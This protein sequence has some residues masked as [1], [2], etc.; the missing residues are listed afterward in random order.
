[1]ELA[2]NKVKSL[3]IVKPKGG[4][5]DQAN[6]G[7]IMARLIELIQRGEKHFLLNCSDISGIDSNGLA[8]LISIRQKLVTIK[9]GSIALCQVS[10][11]VLKIFNITNA[12]HLFIIYRNEEEAIEAMTVNNDIE[13]CIAFLGIDGPLFQMLNRQLP[14]G[15]ELELIASDDD[16]KHQLNKRQYCAVIV[17]DT[18][19]DKL[20]QD[21]FK[22]MPHLSDMPNIILTKAPYTSELKH[23][24]QKKS[25][26]S[27]VAPYPIDE[28]ESY[29]L[30]KELSYENIK[31]LDTG[32]L[33]DAEKL[34]KN[35]TESLDEKFEIM[36]QLL[37]ALRKEGQLEAVETLQ[38]NVHKLS[39]SAG[40][41]GFVKGGE[42]C[43]QLELYLTNILQTG[44]YN[45][46]DIKEIETLFAKLAF[47][48]NIVFYKD[49]SK[50]NSALRPVTPQSIYL[51]STDTT[52]VHFF[53]DVA[54][55][56]SYKIEIEVNPDFALSRIQQ[57]NF[58]PEI[59]IVEQYFQ[60]S[61]HNGVDIISQIKA[62]F[63]SLQMKFALLID[64][65]NLEIEVKAIAAGIDYIIKKPP[66]AADV[67]SLF[68]SLS[69]DRR[70]QPYKILVVDDDIDIGNLIENTVAGYAF[71][72]KILTDE[73]KILE[74]L[75]EF[76]PH[77]LLLD[78]HLP[79]YDGWSLLKIL[80][81]NLRY[82]HL[83]VIIITATAQLQTVKNV[84]QNYDELWLKPLENSSLLKQL[85]KLAEEHYAQSSIQ[86]QF[87]SFVSAKN[88]VKFLQGI[89]IAT[90][91]RQEPIFL[92][93]IGSNE[94]HSIVAAGSW[95]EEEF[96]VSIENL[97]NRLILGEISRTYLGMGRFGFLF[98]HT[99][100]NQLEAMS[101]H[102]H[103]E[104]DYKICLPIKPYD[105]FLS[106]TVKLVPIPSTESN[107]E[108]VLAQALTSFEQEIV[109]IR[110][111]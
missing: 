60:G 95:A 12:T 64:E 91:G 84:N 8:V 92:L 107:A 93:I 17:E 106:F 52:I 11:A 55:E 102:F 103:E 76:S 86:N 2:I 57:L 14:E 1:M 62:N 94:Y 45:A 66:S 25:N 15:L 88:F 98:S 73:T 41:Y 37:L 54:Q 74:T 3:I 65:E 105:L 40:S 33:S 44:S 58:K 90:Q 79:T 6:M 47:Y 109:K 99:D 104:A 35:Y 39:G 72:I 81:T 7:N 32:S 111:D 49:I 29:V 68:C 9:G 110:V 18:K 61:S 19:L 85:T 108:Q 89:M 77:L 70:A 42:V 4:L 24:L 80:R 82:R 75:N 36:E 27:H 5:L 43:K 78:I 10:S 100:E 63:N 28:T 96:L 83:K 34:F 31:P 53:K 26:I 38:K 23:A 51:L 59:V 67:K 97:M 21:L 50:A 56:C 71:E 16:M 87:S 30:L 101:K 46:A 20:Q 69:I 13:K 22:V 48:L